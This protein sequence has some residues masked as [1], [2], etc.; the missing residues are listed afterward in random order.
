V[1]GELGL[2]AF[3]ETAMAGVK[4]LVWGKAIRYYPL[5][6]QAYQLHKIV[7]MKLPV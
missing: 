1:G 6:E 4:P 5:D 2:F 7:R 3:E